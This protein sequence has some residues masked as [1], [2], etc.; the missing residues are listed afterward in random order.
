[1]NWKLAGVVVAA[2]AIGAAVSIAA[3]QPNGNTGHGNPS[4]PGRSVASAARSGDAP[5]AV[6][7][8]FSR[9]T[10]TLLG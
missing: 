6:L 2:A 3:A 7:G 5:S 9:S 10:P 8:V 1:M 4:P